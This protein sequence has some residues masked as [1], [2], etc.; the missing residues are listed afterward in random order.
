MIRDA[1]MEIGGVGL[2]G[3]VSVL[4][5]F[6]VFGVAMV[7]A[8]R[9]GKPFLNTMGDLPLTDDRGVK[10]ETKEACDE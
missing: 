4:L 1:L 2:Y 9:L 7:W 10:R 3:V 8:F 5:F 6:T